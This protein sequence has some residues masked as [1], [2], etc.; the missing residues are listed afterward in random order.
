[1]LLLMIA[2]V[3]WLKATCQ[4][5]TGLEQY[6]YMN[7]KAI[8]ISPKAWYQSSNGWYVEGRYNY[9]EVKTLSV[10]AG[11]TFEKNGDWSYAVTPLAGIVTGKFNGGAVAENATIGYRKFL[12]SLQTQYTFSI[13]D[14]HQNFLY[15][16]ADISYRLFSGL[17]AGMSLQQTSPVQSKA[18]TEKGFFIKTELGKWELPVYIFNINGNNR[19]IV[20]GLIYTNW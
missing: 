17:S 13:E 15:G 5:N 2:S 20:A 8:T 4:S 6:Y 3:W 9:E 12:F 19:Q 1:M 18:K 16:W 7:N 14:R 11:K 10:F